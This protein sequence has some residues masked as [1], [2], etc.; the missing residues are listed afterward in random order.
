MSS[1]SNSWKRGKSA[2]GN[3]DKV[4]RVEKKVEENVIIS[5]ALGGDA[6]NRVLKLPGMEEVAIFPPTRTNKIPRLQPL[7]QFGHYSA[8]S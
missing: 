1:I 8:A 6:R 4:V 5:W 3:D 2:I 7:S